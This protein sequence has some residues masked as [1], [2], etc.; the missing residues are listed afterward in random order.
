MLSMELTPKQDSIYRFIKDYLQDRG[1]AP[2]FRDIGQHLGVSVGTIQDQIKAIIKKGFLQK[3]DWQSRG[4]RL[5]T[6]AFELPILGRV[7]AG[8][9]HAAIQEVEGTVHA[10]PKLSVSQHFALRVKGDSMIEAGILAGDLVIVRAQQTAEDGDIV[11]AR[12]DDETTVKKFK[13]KGGQPIL[14]PANP[15]YS[16]IQ[17]PFE[18]VGKVIE[19]RRQ[20]SK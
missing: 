16:P 17:G 8:P 15:R 7:H 2:S 18:I 5:P 4:L 9:L 19:V 10:G 13:K 20:L 14:L 6:A 11:V 12:I 1:A 3:E